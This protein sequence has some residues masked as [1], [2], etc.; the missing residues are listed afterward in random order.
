MLMRRPLHVRYTTC[1]VQVLCVVMKREDGS[2]ALV[3]QI[4][5][6]VDE[7]LKPLVFDE[8]DAS[9]ARAAAMSSLGPADT[10]QSVA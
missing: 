8:T 4:L 2:V 5:N 7:A 6:K 3:L 9:K 10:R 1:P